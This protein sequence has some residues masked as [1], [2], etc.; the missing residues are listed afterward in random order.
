[1]TKHKILIG[2][3]PPRQQTEKEFTQ[4]ETYDQKERDFSGKLLLENKKK[5]Y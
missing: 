3:I 1:V 5:S 2:L 4:R